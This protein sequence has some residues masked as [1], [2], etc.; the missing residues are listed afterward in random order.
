MSE[1]RPLP[2]ITELNAP[3]YR[4]AAQ[5]KLILQR[6]LEC[7][8]W[9]YYP[10]YGCPFCLSGQLEWESA[11]GRGRL[12]SYTK[13][14]RPQHR[15][16]DD[17]I[18]VILAAVELAEGP[19]VIANLVGDDRGNATVGATVKAAFEVVTPHLGLLMFELAEDMEARESSS[20]SD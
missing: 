17:K 4:A 15:F 7:R 10:R 6:C 5:G 8:E 18:P 13:V 1:D 20:A 16:F 14:F 3:F 11:S 9:V 12:L 19:V 2:V